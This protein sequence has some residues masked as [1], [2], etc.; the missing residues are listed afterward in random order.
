MFHTQKNILALTTHVQKLHAESQ[1]KNRPE[2]ATTKRPTREEPTTKKPNTSI[3]DRAK[4][5]RRLDNV[6]LEVQSFDQQVSD[7]QNMLMSDYS[8]LM[9]RINKVEDGV[10]ACCD[11]KD[12]GRKM[13][14]NGGNNGNALPTRRPTRPTKP[15]TSRPTSRLTTRSPP[16]PPGKKQDGKFVPSLPARQ[17]YC[18]VDENRATIHHSYV[19]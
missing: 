7:L 12:E 19:T 6:E 18:V 2:I 8:N 10:T 1:N 11:G 3:K 17:G 15:P 13:N 14:G 9:R 5:E 16:Q 4:L